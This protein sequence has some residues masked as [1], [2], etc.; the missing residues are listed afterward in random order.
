MTSWPAS[1]SRLAATDESTP[2]DI[3][4]TTRM[5]SGGPRRCGRDGEA[6]SRG[7]GRMP[8]TKSISCLGR[9]GTEA[10]A[11]RIAR[12]GRGQ[13]H[14]PQHVRRL[15]RSG[16]AGRSGGHGDAFE[17]ERDQQ[18]LGLDAIEAD[19]RRVGHAR[20]AIAVDRRARTPRR[21]SA[22]RV[23]R[24]ARRCVP[25]WRT[26]VP[27]RSRRPRR[28]RRAR[29][30]LR[31]GAAVALLPCRRSSCETSRTPRRIHSAPVPFGPPNLW[32]ESE[33]RS[34]PSA[35]TDTGILPTDCTA[36]V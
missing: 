23:D 18:R 15:E 16:R 27:A 12:A 11:Q 19:V 21:G 7:A 3:A 35:L 6:W 13:S 25:P 30:V 28:A 36:S 8:T 5:V 32:P 26:A 31:A 4:T 33:S 17:I 22:A 34:T 10:E 1:T 14:R 20:D 24:E 9:P 2:P 29:D